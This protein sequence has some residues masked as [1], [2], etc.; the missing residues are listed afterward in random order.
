MN[1][2]QRW[3]STLA[4]SAVLATLALHLVTANQS[5]RP[6]ADAGLPEIEII[7]PQWRLFDERGGLTRQLAAERLQQWRGQPST[8]VE[9]RIRLHDRSGQTWQASARRGHL[10]EGDNQLALESD[11]RLAREPAGAG[12]VVSTDYLRIAD[13]GERIET[14]QA[15]VI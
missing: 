8:L 13:Q 4:V 2:R 6:A 15:V 9:P 5:G 1:S 14:N 7:S 3:A 12:P 10:L 11:V